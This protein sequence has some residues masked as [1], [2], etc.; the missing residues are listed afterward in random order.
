M[1]LEISVARCEEGYLC[2]V[3]GLEVEVI[4]DSDLYL[5][6]ILGDVPPLALPRSRERHLRCNPAISQYI[7][8][9]NFSPVMCDG[10]FDKRQLDPEYVAEEERRISR[11]WR[12]LQEIPRLGLTIP[13]YPFPEVIANWTRTSQP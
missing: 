11:A 8:D 9:G 2:D 4:T 6:Y 12:R 1:A 13:E 7:V 3:C 5:R 10:V